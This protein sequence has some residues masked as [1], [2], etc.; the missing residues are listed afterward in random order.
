MLAARFIVDW[1][2]SGR[3]LSVQ[4]VELIV[5]GV[6]FRSFGKLVPRIFPGKFPRAS[7][8]NRDVFRHWIVLLPAWSLTE[9]MPPVRILGY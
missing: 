3:A 1:A 2:W 8:G 9:N 7:A 6:V 4:Y 5:Y